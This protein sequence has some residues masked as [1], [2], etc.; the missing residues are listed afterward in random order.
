[1]LHSLILFQ[2][3]PPQYDRAEDLA[4]LRY[5]NESSCLHTLRQR[6]GSNL[7]HTYAGPNLIVINPQQQLAIYTDKVSNEEYFTSVR[8]TNVALMLLCRVY[9]EKCE[10]CLSLRSRGTRERILILFRRRQ[11]LRFFGLQFG[12][13]SEFLQGLW[14]SFLCPLGTKRG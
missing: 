4:S 2:A 5:L 7:I 3:N 14:A 10:I 8:A 1:M 12:R 11:K 6:F 13:P 9:A